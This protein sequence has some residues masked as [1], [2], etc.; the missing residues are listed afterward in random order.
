MNSKIRK[1]CIF[2]IVSFTISMCMAPSFCP[3]F[4]DNFDKNSSTNEDKNHILSEKKSEIARQRQGFA[5]VY[6]KVYDASTHLPIEGANIT[7]CDVE[8]Y[9][10]YNSVTSSSGLATFSLL[11]TYEKPDYLI[12]KKEGYHSEKLE[13]YVSHELY[14]NI[15]LSP[16]RMYCVDGT[17]YKDGLGV[18]GEVYFESR[19]SQ[20]YGVWYETS[21]DK[22]GKYSIELPEGF[23]EV[24][25]SY[26]DCKNT[27]FIVVNRTIT[28]DF[29]LSDLEWYNFTI[30]GY[31]NDTLG[32]AL[33]PLGVGISFTF[34]NSDG[35]RIFEEFSAFDTNETRGE[36][37]YKVRLPR[38]SGY[39]QVLAGGFEGYLRKRVVREIT[40]SL[41]WENIS[42]ESAPEETATLHVSV[43]NFGEDREDTFAILCDLKREY[44]FFSSRI[45]SS[46][47]ID[48]QVYGSEYALVV[49]DAVSFDMNVSQV[50]IGDYEE[51][52]VDCVLEE[53]VKVEE[54]RTDI[55]F[56]DWQNVTVYRSAK[57]TKTESILERLMLECGG[58]VGREVFDKDGRLVRDGIISEPETYLYRNSSRYGTLQ[59]SNQFPIFS[60]EGKPFMLGD[61][62]NTTWT[63]SMTT[64]A[65]NSWRAWNWS[66]YNYEGDIFSDKKVVINYSYKMHAVSSVQPTNNYVYNVR[67]EP[68]SDGFEGIMN[69]TYHI[70]FPNDMT[71]NH[72]SNLSACEIDPSYYEYAG[73]EIFFDAGEC[74]ISQNAYLITLTTD[75]EKP[76]IINYTI[77]T[78]ANNGSILKL[79][80]NVTD[81]E[82]GIGLVFVEYL[83]NISGGYGY[84]PM[85]NLGNGCYQTWLGPVYEGNFKYRFI[86]YDNAFNFNETEFVNLLVIPYVDTVNPVIL[87]FTSLETLGDS[88]SVLIYA[89]IT[90]DCA[91]L[92]A[93]LHLYF[94]GSERVIQMTK[95][96]GESW[97][98]RISKLPY[99]AGSVVY[100]ITANDTS[101]NMAT[102]KSK[103][104]TM[105]DSTPPVFMRYMITPSPTYSHSKITLTVSVFD[106]TNV[107][108]NATFV[109]RESNFT[110]RMALVPIP[111][112]ERTYNYTITINPIASRDG[113][114][115]VLLDAKDDF[116]NIANKTIEIRIESAIEYIS[117]E[118]IG[119]PHPREMISICGKIKSAGNYTG[120]GFELYIE[121]DN[122]G[123][124]SVILLPDGNYLYNFSL[125][126]DLFEGVHL[127]NL[128][129]Y[130]LFDKHTTK[131]TIG[132][133]YRH[134]HFKTVQN[135]D[136]SIILTVILSVLL[137]GML[138][139][140]KHRAGKS[141]KEEDVNGGKDKVNEEKNNGKLEDG[142]NK[143]ERN[144]INKMEENKIN[145]IEE[146]KIDK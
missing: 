98:V 25:V 31:I 1:L 127:F 62:Y 105:R 94:G 92:N 8:R 117:A 110:Y 11:Y 134:P 5:E 75:K 68:I 23:Y 46:G 81:S 86:V 133:S 18:N 42:L 7:L 140:F 102:S 27:S 51:K 40:S 77:L 44:M 112:A 88:E 87:D 47:K 82:S 59:E 78:T 106:S 135:F 71:I 122:M 43:S 6:C 26:E 116:G 69:N 146:N 20:S 93:Q 79:Y 143:I 61:E 55:V 57:L 15:Y 52:N 99:S 145:K 12:V 33:D 139:A 115:L 4:F 76:E 129:L 137:V 13:F 123:K 85:T 119:K 60:T 30:Q 50:S 17:V 138:Y 73:S 114:V 136:L 124:D 56:S 58:L 24:R 28:L 108:L 3:S 38:L 37:E 63:T 100:Y 65:W 22:N 14:M 120:L 67:F 45:N 144:K 66:I 90:D 64:S 121:F 54:Y 10:F 49:V 74:E 95:G 36:Y 53:Y 118:I 84:T 80:L 113:S 107:T 72:I 48:W 128:T 35:E 34:W 21:C 83:G 70:F 101:Y 126:A 39:V 19:D 2:F 109:G 103:S 131:C 130:D 132:F 16:A 111:I 32:N 141:E 142:K 97:Y 9:E 91:V 96:N 125:P 104:F 29:F 41:I 89:N